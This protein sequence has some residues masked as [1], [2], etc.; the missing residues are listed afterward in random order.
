MRTHSTSIC[1]DSN[2]ANCVNHIM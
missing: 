1:M 2:A